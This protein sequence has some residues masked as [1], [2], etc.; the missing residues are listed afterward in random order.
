MPRISTA[1]LPVLTTLFFLFAALL[2]AQAQPAPRSRIL[3]PVDDARVTILSGNTHPL[4][5]PEFD[6]G[7]IPDTTPL[8]HIVLLLQRSPEQESALQQLL[9]QQQDKTT[10]AFH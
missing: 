3:Q 10:S 5:R 8:G 2:P 6:Q 4:A 1:P 9:D 7:A